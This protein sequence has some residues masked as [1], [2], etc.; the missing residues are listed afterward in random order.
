MFEHFVRIYVL[1]ICIIDVKYKK[2]D[3]ISI[4]FN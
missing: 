1:Q 3:Y 4:Y 2:V